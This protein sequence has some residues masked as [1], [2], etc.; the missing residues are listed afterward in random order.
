M[1]AVD[2][3]H[4]VMSSYERLTPDELSNLAIVLGA[5]RSFRGNRRKRLAYVGM[6]ITSGRRCFDVLLEHGVQTKE[7]LSSKLGKNALL[8]LVI[9]P[10]VLEGIA[11]TD[12]LS[13]N[14]ELLFIAPSIFEAKTWRWS[15]DAYMSLWY[16]VL[17]EMV[18]A[19][20]VMDGWEYSGGCVAEV[21]FSMLM[22]WRYIQPL[23]F[24]HT[25]TSYR[26]KNFFP[27][28]LEQERAK[29]LEAMWGIRV[30]DQRG[31]E[32]GL[33]D[34]LDAVVAA[35]RDLRKKGL[36]YDSL[37][38]YGYVLKDIPSLTP[39][40]SYEPPAQGGR[41]YL[42]DKFWIACDFFEEG[43]I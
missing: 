4:D 39:F 35:I 2:P 22:Q 31:K 13:L 11:L 38:S 17:G 37:M 42:T 36:S 23:H 21:V 5:Y 16:R 32:L 33:D 29:E 9:K 27:G 1:N 7:E 18:G 40:D 25:A 43:A 26:L 20:Y 24:D 30:Y 15:Q 19:H 10:N 6:P 12:A 34:I 41:P 8:D 14:H 3:L 28:M